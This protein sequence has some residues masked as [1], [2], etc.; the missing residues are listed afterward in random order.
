MLRRSPPLLNGGLRLRTEESP[1]AEREGTRDLPPHGGFVADHGSSPTIREIGDLASISSTNGVRYHLSL[2]EN[3]DWIQRDKRRS[4]GIQLLRAADGMRALSA[5]STHR[6]DS[7]SGIPILGRVAAGQPIEAQEDVEGHVTLDEMF[8]AR[9]DLFALRVQGLSMRDRGILAGDVVVV[10]RQQHAREGD[11]VVALVGDEAT[12]KT[13]RR[14]ADAIELVPENPDF[15]T[16]R[17]EREDE[18]RIVGVVGGL[19]RPMG[20][21]RRT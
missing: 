3:A 5:A 7:A 6:A 18:V 1:H 10:R 17:F 20:I 16:L 9:D 15:Q 4:R 14:T 11:A 12:V 13:F 8:P 19:A 21:P 2:L